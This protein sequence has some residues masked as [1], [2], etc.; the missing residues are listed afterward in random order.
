VSAAAS[1]DGDDF[2]LAGN[3]TLTFGNQLLGPLDVSDS[4]SFLSV[5]CNA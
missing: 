2:P 3:T 5:R 4:L 1:D